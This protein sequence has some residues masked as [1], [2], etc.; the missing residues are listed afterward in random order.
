MVRLQRLALLAIAL[1]LVVARLVHE[2]L[3]ALPSSQPLA[4]LEIAPAD[5]P[6][7]CTCCVADTPPRAAR[8]S[9][10]VVRRPADALLGLASWLALAVRAAPL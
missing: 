3:I 4:S 8:A 2:A 5:A 7:G 9:L 10:I 6:P 1:L